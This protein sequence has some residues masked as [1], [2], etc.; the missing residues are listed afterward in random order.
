MDLPTPANDTATAP[1]RP[2]HSPPN[3]LAAHLALDL[4][5]IAVQLDE[6]MVRLFQP[7]TERQRVSE[8]RK[9]LLPPL[10]AAIARARRGLERR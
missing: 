9:R 7:E 2:A 5:F 4:G 8:A 3:V 6:L 1:P 10:Q